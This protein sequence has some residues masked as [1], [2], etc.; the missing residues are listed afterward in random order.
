M[1]GDEVVQ[2]LSIGA[3]TIFFGAFVLVVVVVFSKKRY[4]LGGHE[5]KEIEDKVEHEKDLPVPDV[6]NKKENHQKSKGKPHKSK[7]PSFSHPQLLAN[8]KGHT[9][10]VFQ[11][12]FSMCGKYLASC[13]EG[14]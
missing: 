4:A 12:D 10:A 9:G 14:R 7:D 8:L 5:D 2:F 1:A 11:L 13:S 3:L 6:R